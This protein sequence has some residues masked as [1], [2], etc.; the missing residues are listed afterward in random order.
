MKLSEEQVQLRESARA[1]LA[2]QCSAAFVRAMEKSELGFSREM[3]KEMAELGWLGISLPEQYGGLE[4]GCLDQVILAK[5][6]GRSIC[7]VP[8][9]S[10]AVIGAEALARAGSDAQKQAFLPGIAAGDRVVAFAFQEH[11]RDFDAG[12]IRLRA[13]QEGSDYLLDGAKLFVEW[14]GAADLLL[15]VARTSGEPPSRNGLTLFLVDARSAGIECKRTPT[16]ARDQHFELIF[17]NVRVPKD[18]VLGRVDGAWSALEGVIERAA[19]VFSAFTVGLSERMHELAT[20]FARQRVQFDRP[21]GQMQLIQNYLATLI[22]EIYGADTIVLFTAFNMDRGRRVRDYVAKTKAFCA[23]TVKR[24]ADIGS[25][26]FGGTGYMEET[27]TTLYLRR[28]KQYQLMLGGVDYWEK[29]IAEE[30]LDAPG[31]APP[32]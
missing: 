15:V 32:G 11:S 16:L 27:D 12:A 13:R 1:L 10:T 9:L 20:A 3:W 2:K 24:T 17:R 30:L 7:P 28:G 5:E 22:T 19:V 14:A 18:R 6:L 29:I 21:I 31:A 23:Q 25:Q 4:L 8:F 26:I